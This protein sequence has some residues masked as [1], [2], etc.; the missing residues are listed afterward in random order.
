MKRTKEEAEQ[1]RQDLLVAALTIF[2]RK[3]LEAARLEDIAEAAGVTRGAVYHHFGGKNELYL[4]L[5][6]EASQVGSQAIQ[7]AIQEGGTFLQVVR[8]IL[9]YSL[10]LLEEDTRFRQV[11]ALS[12]Q[13]SQ[14][15]GRIERERQQAR[16]LVQS[17]VGFFKIGIEQ[18]EVRPDIDPPT[19]A[20]AL[21]GYQNGLSMLWLANR[22][23]FSIK[24]SADALA[25]IYVRGIAAQQEV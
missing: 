6:E 4:A 19:A 5:M 16:S 10:S 13:T 18:G 2:S 11:M 20:R 17:I 23:A 15:A 3:G 12:L 9:V 22:E 1:T 24:D 8:R 14:S 21:L 7:K 25:E